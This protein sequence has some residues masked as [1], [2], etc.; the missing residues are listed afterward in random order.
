LIHLSRRTLAQVGLVGFPNAGKSSFLA[1]TS[2]ARPHVAP[3]PFTTLKPQ[4]GVLEYS[5]HGRI[6]VADIPGLVAGAVTGGSGG[7]KQQSPTS[8]GSGSSSSSSSSSRNH[9]SSKPHRGLGHGF[10]RHIERVSGLLFVLD[11]AGVDGRD[12]VEDLRLLVAELEAYE[13]GLSGRPSVVIANKVDLPEAQEHLPRL[14]ALLLQEEARTAAATAT[15][16]A[17]AGDTAAAA[18]A[19]AAVNRRG[20]PADVRG[21]FETSM[22]TGTGLGE[23]VIA[24]RAKLVDDDGLSF[25]R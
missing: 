4:V 7:Q 5:D 19:A 18:A 6:T 14:R 21:F 10:L 9:S 23:T 17:A 3:Y 1:A 24:L 15:A 12:P 8:S 11:A 13:E 20:L 22:A 25:E 16:A 2:N